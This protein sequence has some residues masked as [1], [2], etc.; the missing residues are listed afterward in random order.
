MTDWKASYAGYDDATLALIGN[1]GLVRRAAKLAPEARWVDDAIQVGDMMVRLDQKGPAHGRCPC[2]TAGVCVHVLAAAMFV[3]DGLGS[4][5]V[6]ED[7]VP[8]LQPTPS[9]R[10]PNA[11]PDSGPS[12]RTRA[13]TARVRAEI[14]TDI[15]IGFSHLGD[16]AADRLAGLAV[17]TRTAGL[18]LLSHYLGTAT[19]LLGG[20]AS[21]DDDVSETDFMAS[22]ARCWGLAVALDHADADQWSRLR[23]VARREYSPQDDHMT[24]L[25]LGA[26]W[27]VTPSGA[28]GLTLTTWDADSAELR[29]ATTSRPAGLDPSF[30]PSQNN[31]AL[32]N[33]P[34]SALLDGPFRI[35]GPRLSAD[36]V[37]SATARSVTCLTHAKASQRG[38]FS[39]DTLNGVAQKLTPDAISPGFADASR[40]SALVAVDGF[41][42]LAIDEPQQQLV[43][44]LPAGRSSWQLRQEITDA[45]TNRGDTLLALDAQGVKPNFVL[46]RRNH[47]RGQAVWE[48]VSVFLSQLGGSRL[49]ALDF[50]PRNM[51]GASSVLQKQWAALRRRWQTSPAAPSASRT[52]VAVVCDDVRDLLV[53]LAATGRLAPSPEQQRRLQAIS[54][55]CDDL[56]LGTMAKLVQSLLVSPDAASVLRLQLVTDRVGLLASNP[57]E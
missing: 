28:R 35:D 51:A 30:G 50:P 20:L 43:W 49:I 4:V 48:P 31:T 38:L 24:L 2:P 36:G 25:P 55:R 8:V 37:L 13:V 17:D 11:V 32:W 29:T 34:L 39:N 16:D 6:P 44:T 23:G 46:A 18:V 5:T 54:A 10:Q 15:D 7:F 42:E 12:E 45:T 57:T 33:K 21:N 27:W 26:T 14:E 53:D 41:G 1:P 3:R 9:R 56:A 19:A 47:L 22:L 40:P 52:A